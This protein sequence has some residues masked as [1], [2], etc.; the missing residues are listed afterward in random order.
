M[1]IISFLAAVFMCFAASAQEAVAPPPDAAPGSLPVAKVGDHEITGEEFGRFARAKLHRMTLET[2]KEVQADG[3]FRVQTMSELIATHILVALAKEAN[4]TVTDEQ[5]NADFEKSKE[6]FKTPEDYQTYLKQQGTTEAE[7]RD[8][9]RKKLL[10]DAFVEAK[11][12]DLV[13]SPEEV[14]TQYDELKAKGAMNRDTKTADLAQIVALFTPGDQASED[15]AKAKVEKVRERILKGEKFEDVG[16]EISK[17]PEDGIQM[18]LID[19][20]RPASLFPDIAKAVEALKEG[21]MSDILKTPRG[22]GIVL[23]KAWYEPGTVPLEKVAP[24]LERELRVKKQRD[25]IGELIK[26]A[27]EHIPIE[28]YKAPVAEAKP[29]DASKGD[30]PAAEAPA[31]VPA[32]DL[33][34]SQ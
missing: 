27:R 2:G 16:N 17:N 11:T 24:K 26:A 20:A 29:E 12:K 28:I 6:F 13:V 30:T 8:D 22:Y 14:K 19:E 5:V 32:A 7:L 3:K 25:S 31:P 33:S 34:G 4:I 10:I 18:G 1:K 9:V 15:A 23:L 21:E